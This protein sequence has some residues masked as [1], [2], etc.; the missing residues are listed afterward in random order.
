[1][2][3]NISVPKTGLANAFKKLSAGKREEILN[4]CIREFA[5]KG[6]RNASTNNIVKGL[7]ISKGTL[8][9]YF[10]SKSNI[11]GYIFE[12]ILQDYMNFIRDRIGDLS[13]DLLERTRQIFDIGFDYY[14]EHP[15]LY[16]M[17][18]KIGMEDVD[19]LTSDLRERYTVYSQEIFSILYDGVKTEDLRLGLE[20]SLQILSTLILGMKMEFL[21]VISEKS[22]L[23]QMREYF[24]KKWELMLSAFKHGMYK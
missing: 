4:A 23:E 20:G 13:S 17:F 16:R 8:F 12:K 11:Y 15:D 18:M 7:G 19:M 5:D 1:M 21:Q 6:Y 14:R 3:N 2:K 24:N 22:D 10:S 9:N